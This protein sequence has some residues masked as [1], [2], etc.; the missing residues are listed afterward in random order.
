VEL[1]RWVLQSVESKTAEIALSDTIRQS[2]RS[3]QIRLRLIMKTLSVECMINFARSVKCQAIQVFYSIS[4]VQCE[5]YRLPG[6]W[7]ATAL[8]NDVVAMTVTDV[9]WTEYK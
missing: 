6:L 7:K 1:V 8:R 2:N 3:S 5:I 4:T 9:H